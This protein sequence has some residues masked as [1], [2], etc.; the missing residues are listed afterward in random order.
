MHTKQIKNMRLPVIFVLLASSLSAMADGYDLN[1]PFGFCTVSSRTDASSTYAVTGGG[2]YTYPIPDGFTGRVTVLTSKGPGV[3]MKGDIQNGIKNNE[4]LIL[5]GSKGEFYV[6]ESIG[7]IFSNRTI[8]GINNA[9]ICTMWYLTDEDKTL[10]DNATDP[11]TPDKVGVKNMSTNASDNLG[12]TVAGNTIKEQAEYI[13]RKLLYEKYHSEDYRKS[14]ILTLQNCENVIIRNITFQGPGAVDVGGYDLLSCLGAKHIWIDHCAFKDGMDGN[15]D[16]TNESDFNTVSWCTF[17]YTD[18]SYQH[19]N[20]NLVGSTDSG[21][22]FNKDKTHLNT[23]FAFNWWGT[24]CNQRMPMARVGKIHM[25]NNY[26]SCS[27]AS[28][29]MN[30]RKLSEFLIDGNYFDTGVKRYYS[31]NDATAVNWTSNNHITEAS[32]LP[33]SFGTV[34]VPYTVTAAPCAEVPTEVKAHAGAKLEYGDI[35]E[36]TVNSWITWPFS[37][38]ESNQTATLNGQS[39]TGIGG[40]AITLGDELTYG[41]GADPTKNK[42]LTAGGYSE[43]LIWQKA[44]N[45]EAADGNAITFSVMP[46]NGYTLQ[47]TNVSFIATRNGTDKGKMDVKWVDANGTVNLSTGV[48]PKRNNTPSG[49]PDES[50]YYT[51]FDYPL[52]REATTGE[53]KLVINIYDLAFYDSN[54]DNV[55]TPKSYGL[56]NIAF[57]G[58]LTNTTGISTPVTISTSQNVTYYNIKG[59]RVAHPTKGLYIVRSAGD[60]KG[61]KVFI[62]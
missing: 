47:V 27:G 32:S 24:G 5:D 53:S 48:T 50:P 42:K 51:L 40:V 55:L 43:T 1:K 26:Y 6:K 2:C 12:G 11:R 58:V 18:R 13:T 30:P 37:T 45:N 3:D 33:T 59:Q 28:L 38:G 19:Q 20:T 15:F 39:E 52:E 36:P 35:I 14:G 4:V 23:T 29:C 41:T 16:I 46:K 10:L 34:A 62:K 31:Q 25:L 17:N 22:Q 57:E 7:N 60:T 61:K 44:V 9:K 56:C 8:I 54:K 49:K 21:D